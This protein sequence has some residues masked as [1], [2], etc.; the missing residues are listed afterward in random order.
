MASNSFISVKVQGEKEVLRN[1]DAYKRYMNIEVQNALEEVLE[2]ITEKAKSLAPVDT[3]KLRAS[4]Q[5]VVR[6]MASDIIEGHI[7]ATVE[8]A[9]LI[10][11]GTENMKAQPFLTPALDEGLKILT[12]KLQE[13]HKR[14]ARR[15]GHQF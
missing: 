7:E 12:R 6:R 5:G 8:Y 11:F 15:L 2:L 13:A 3:G 4:V 10:E 1:M 14:A 9:T